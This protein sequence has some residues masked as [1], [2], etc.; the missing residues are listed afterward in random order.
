MFVYLIVRGR[1]TGARGSQRAHRYEEEVRSFVREAAGTTGGTGH[2]GE[3]SGLAEL[4]HRRD[5]TQG[6]YEQAKAKVLVG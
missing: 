5:L 2:V 6:E 1:G 3:R 4:K